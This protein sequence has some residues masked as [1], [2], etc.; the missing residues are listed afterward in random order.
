MSLLYHILNAL[1][2]RLCFNCNKIVKKEEPFLCAGCFSKILIYQKPFCAICHARLA[3]NK[4][5]CHKNAQYILTAATAYEDLIKKLIWNLK[6]NKKLT[7]AEPLKKI[8]EVYFNNLT[9][10]TSPVELII[11][12]PLHPTKER[13]RGFNQS[14]L[15]AKTIAKKLNLPIIENCLI[16]IKNTSPQMELK[17]REERAKNIWQSFIIKNPADI[18]GKNILLVDDVTTTGSTFVEA[19]KTLKSAGAKKIIAF[20]IAKVG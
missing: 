17:N 4:K 7:A 6:Y 18:T 13:Q 8:T 11:P 3:N 12:I 19:A 10:L 5:I 1:F 20:A 9:N 16:K 15:I 2:P 14:V